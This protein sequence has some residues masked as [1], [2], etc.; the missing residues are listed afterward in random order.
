MFKVLKIYAKLFYF[1][2]IVTPRIT[3]TRS[4]QLP[5]STIRGVGDSQHQRYVESVTLG[6]NNTGSRRLYAS[7]ICGV[8]YT[9]YHRSGE[10]SFKKFNS[11]L[12]VSVMQ[13]VVHSGYQT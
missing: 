10:F 1:L 12:S 4:R 3:D 11:R 7:L 6:L 5:D 8:D 13:G 2:Q 9:P